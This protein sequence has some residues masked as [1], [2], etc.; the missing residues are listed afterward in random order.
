[1]GEGTWS[2][3]VIGVCLA[4]V[5]EERIAWR[6]RGR[7]ARGKLTVID[8]DPGLGK[9]TVMMDWAARV[10]RGDPLPDGEPQD[11]RGVL[12]L[13]AEDDPADTI[14]P[15]LRLMGADLSQIYLLN[16]V[17]DE[18]GMRMAAL[19]TDCDLIE[20][21]IRAR[22][23]GLVV[24]D[25]LTAFLAEDLKANSDQD[26]RRALSPLALVAQRTGASVILLRHLNKTAS[27]NA[28]Y[29]GGGSI[30]IIGIARFGL[31]VAE[32]R[33]QGDDVRI[34]AS[35]K[36]N[37]GPPPASLAYRLVPV[38]GEDHAVVEWIGT[39][40]LR[41]RDLLTEQAADDETRDEWDDAVEWLR[42]FL[43][44]GPKPAKAVYD[45]G[46]RVGIGVRA[47]RRAKAKLGVRAVKHGFS[48]ET[49]WRWTLEPAS[50]ESPN[51]I[52]H[53]STDPT[54]LVAF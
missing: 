1:M 47:I 34:L 27:V 8:G 20:A 2:P 54:S 4:D 10:S 29:R 48:G 13:C 23:V 19:P 18:R 38:P 32:D 14:R 42:G 24:I 28:L 45:E 5:R 46:R 16:E 30:G 7:V 36:S 15:R 35:T 39:S 11:E 49:E 17:P 12:L 51:G 26:V 3:V 40:D 44:D 21:I 22:N 6:S 25:P 52:A 31:L 41:A 50:S 9:S 53:G 33:N 43:G 37:V